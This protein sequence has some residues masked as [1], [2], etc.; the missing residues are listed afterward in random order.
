MIADQ[1]VDA[2][3]KDHEPLIAE[4]LNESILIVELPNQWAMYFDGYT[5]HGLGASILFITPQGDN[6]TKAY[7]IAFPCMN[8]VS[9]YEA[10]II[11]LRMVV[12]WKIK[13]LQVYGDSQLVIR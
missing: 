2:P 12:E 9:K 10:L 11:G 3:A 5:Q 13:E 6:I 4:F 8:N 1:L 7:W